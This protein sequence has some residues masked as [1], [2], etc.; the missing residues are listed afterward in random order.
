MEQGANIIIIGQAEPERTAEY[1]KR[2][3]LS[4]TILSDS[5]NKVYQGYG[6]LEGDVSQILY[7]LPKFSYQD[8]IDLMEVR[9]ATD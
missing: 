8:G 1:A 4:R 7:G 3:K 5:S 9:K 6:L 2:N